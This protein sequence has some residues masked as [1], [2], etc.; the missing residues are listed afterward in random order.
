MD[1]DNS[2]KYTLKFEDK[3]RE[4]EARSNTREGGLRYVDMRRIKMA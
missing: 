1:E 3:N 4:V 2:D